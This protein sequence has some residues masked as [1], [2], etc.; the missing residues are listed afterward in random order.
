MNL[1]R[2]SLWFGLGA[3]AGAVAGAIV[4]RSVPT[5][6]VGVVLRPPGAAADF[7]ATCIRCSRCVDACP[8]DVLAPRPALSG[9]DA[10]TPAFVARDN[11]CNL[12]ADREAMQCI[13]ACP[14]GALAAVASL[15]EVRIGTAVV[16]PATCFAFNGVTCRACW[17]ACPLA[18]KAIRLDAKLHP[19]V[20]ADHCIGCGL[21][22]HACLTD[23][24]SIVVR[25]RGAA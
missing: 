19:V 15:T 3:G 14:T 17:H 7:L 9:S 8:H 11:P 6:K 16:D 23:P 10:W 12:C 5:A 4:A 1:T 18:G 13:A 24:A 20:D 21:C 2:R 22:E 25:A